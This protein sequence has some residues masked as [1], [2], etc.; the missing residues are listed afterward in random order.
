MV[1]GDAIA[2]GIDAF[3]RWWPSVRPRLEASI[4]GAGW[5]QRLIDEVDEHVSAIHPELSW[6]LNPGRRAEN[7]FCLSAHGDPDLRGVTER[8]VRSAPPA[9][10]GWEFHPSRPARPELTLRIG[11]DE[12]A[13]AEVVCHFEID[14]AAGT[15]DV[16]LHHPAFARL[17]DDARDHAA[18]LVLDGA[19]GEDAV[20]RW[21]GSI[22]SLPTAPQAAG[23]LSE[24]VNLVGELSHRA[25]SG[26]SDSV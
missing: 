12:I 24:L 9:D 26:R 19:L 17:D 7:A 11:E 10:Q 25:H 1:T 4:G 23:P 16:T 8:W 22:E 18:F 14:E 20:E 15:I 3:W 6:E 21:I 2:A 5:D 13:P